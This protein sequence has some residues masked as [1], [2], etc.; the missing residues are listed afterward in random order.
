MTKKKLDPD[1]VNKVKQLRG[2]GLSWKNIWLE[3]GI[4]PEIAKR[5]RCYK[6]T[7]TVT[8]NTFKWSMY[9]NGVY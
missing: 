8:Q 6:N 5:V 7:V 2:Q 1:K 3:T 9:P 4:R